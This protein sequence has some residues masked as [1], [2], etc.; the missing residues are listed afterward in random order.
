MILSGRATVR[1]RATISANN[2]WLTSSFSM[3]LA[4]PRSVTMTVRPQPTTRIPRERSCTSQRS[5][6]L[7]GREFGQEFPATDRAGTGS[8]SQS[9]REERGLEDPPSRVVKRR[10]PG[11][12]QRSSRPR[13]IILLPRGESGLVPT[14]WHLAGRAERPPDNPPGDSMRRRS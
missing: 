1:M 4:S 10:I 3:I 8:R 5:Q 2:V 9:G 7:V 11:R 6:P 14:P 13:T 12:P